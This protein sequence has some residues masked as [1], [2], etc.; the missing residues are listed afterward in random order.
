MVG[1][2]TY[3]Q[4]GKQET[5]GCVPNGMPDTPS[6]P[7]LR[8][9]AT[10]IPLGRPNANQRTYG[11]DAFSGTQGGTALLLLQES[12]IPAGLVQIAE[13]LPDEVRLT[14]KLIDTVSGHLA[15]DRLHA[16]WT[17]CQVGYGRLVGGTVQDYR[18][19]HFTIVR[20]AP[21]GTGGDVLSCNGRV[22]T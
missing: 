20:P 15:A 8:E 5:L 11:A 10:Q 1:V 17:V 12:R 3:V 21:S 19:R 18:L 7:L 9:L 4:Y 14:V 2:E 22:S 16:G 13:V 6:S